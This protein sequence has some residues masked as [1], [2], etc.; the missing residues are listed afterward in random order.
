MSLH[1]LR[2]FSSRRFRN[3]VEGRYSI[4]QRPSLITASCNRCNKPF[5]FHPIEIPTVVYSEVGGGYARVKGEICGIVAGTGACTKCGQ[6][7]GAINWPEAAYIA[8]TIPG[9]VVWAWNT[10]FI[11]ALQAKISG[12]KVK[13]RHML[14][15]DWH[16]VRFTSL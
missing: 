2:T 1:L 5:L 11:P 13:L 14:M 3:P 7:V 9:G 12:D 6:I 4:Y 15:F 10:S 8:I 16:L